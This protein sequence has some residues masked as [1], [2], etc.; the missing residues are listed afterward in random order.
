MSGMQLPHEHRSINMSVP[1]SKLLQCLVWDVHAAWVFQRHI[2]Q[3]GVNL[4][5]SNL[6]GR[7]GIK[8]LP[9]LRL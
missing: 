7:S 5:V 8:L 6:T 1:G 4:P 9:L 2:W 3:K